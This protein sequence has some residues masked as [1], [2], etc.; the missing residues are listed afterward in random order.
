MEKKILVLNASSG[1][2]GDMTVGALLDL[3]AD[4]D[5]LLRAIDSLQLEGAQVAISRVKRSALDACDFD[6]VLDS[7]HENHDHDMAYLHPDRFSAGD[8]SEPDHD[9]HGSDCHENDHQ[10]H[11]HL[12]HGSHDHG[13]DGHD[14]HDHNQH[15]HGCHDHDH[16]GH[17]HH[18]HHG[19]N[20]ADIERILRSGDLSEG[21]LS[22][23]LKVF[24]VVAEAESK[25]HGE[26]IERV[27]FHEVGAVDSIIDIA[28]AA[29]CI[30]NLGITDVIVT[31]LSEGTGTVMCQHGLLPVPVPATAQILSSYHLS[32]GILQ[33]VKGELITPTGAA[34]LA[35][36]KA[37]ETLPERFRIVR[38][39]LGAGKR[40]YA[41]SGILRAMLIDAADSG[42]HT[43]A[44]ARIEN[45]EGRDEI[46]K[47]ETNIDDSTGEALGA[48]MDLLLEEGAKDVFYVPAYMKK[49]R[50]S[51]VLNVICSETDKARLEEV[52][53]RN[54][55]TIGIRE[56]PCGRTV[57]PRQEKTLE[58]PWGMAEIK[59]CRIGG[60]SVIYPEADSV[61]TLSRMNGIGYAEMYHLVKA[62]ASGTV[63]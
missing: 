33:N 39:G 6:V 49:N 51:Y 16:H 47:L 12:D 8:A 1:I 4:Q 37:G 58:T 60:D 23:A 43:G 14:H 10:D 22:L 20:L 38:N 57:L 42:K 28:A 63:V 15:K 59:I 48:V 50:P 44:A 46:I 52:I 53:F 26:T 17:G 32:F 41:T 61:K 45:R 29:V 7:E 27:H 13:H 54:T 35:A 18:H 31:D 11:S 25:V 55:T 36:L 34:I 62:Y 2:S 5:V 3:G 30:D 24:R 56:I 9:H 21:A 40:D 19:R